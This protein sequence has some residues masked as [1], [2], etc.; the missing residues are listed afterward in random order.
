MTELERYNQY[1][2]AWLGRHLMKMHPGLMD[3][4]HYPELLSFTAA[5]IRHVRALERGQAARVRRQRSDARRNT[6]TGRMRQRTL[7]DPQLFWY[8]L[9]LVSEDR[10]DKAAGD[11]DLRLE[12]I[13]RWLMLRALRSADW[14][15]AAFSCQFFVSKKDHAGLTGWPRY[16]ADL[17]SMHESLAAKGPFPEGVAWSDGGKACFDGIFPKQ[18]SAAPKLAKRLKLKDW[19]RA[20]AK[21]PRIVGA[22]QRLQPPLGAPCFEKNEKKIVKLV[23]DDEQALKDFVHGARSDFDGAA[24]AEWVRRKELLH[25]FTCP[26][27]GLL[28]HELE[29]F[30]DM[31]PTFDTS[32]PGA[33]IEPRSAPPEPAVEPALPP[34]DLPRLQALLEKANE[35]AP[36]T[37]QLELVV[38]ATVIG[39]VRLGERRLF[40]VPIDTLLLV[41]ALEQPDAPL[42]AVSLSDLVDGGEAALETEL[43]ILKLTLEPG[44]TSDDE[45]IVAS[46]YTVPSGEA[47]AP[48]SWLTRLREAIADLRS[49]RGPG[50]VLAMVAG[51]IAAFL[52]WKERTATESVHHAQANAAS[53][54]AQARA[55]Q[56]RA[57]AYA[58]VLE[59][60]R[61]ADGL[62]ERPLADFDLA[63]AKPDR[64]DSPLPGT[65]G[66]RKP[67]GFDR[68]LQDDPRLQSSF[69]DALQR[70]GEALAPMGEAL[71]KAGKRDQ[72]IQLFEYLHARKGA[73][74]DIGFALG[75]LYKDVDNQK[76]I[77]VYR[78]MLDPNEKDPRVLHYLGWSLYESGDSQAAIDSLQR[79]LVAYDR[80]AQD[81][82]RHGADPLPTYGKALLNLGV[83]YANLHQDA[84]ATEYF[85]KAR[86]SFSEAARRFGLQDPKVAFSFAILEA[87]QDHWE[88]ALQALQRALIEPTYLQRAKEEKAF[89]PLRQVGHPLH[90]SFED[91]LARA[92]TPK[93]TYGMRLP[94]DFDPTV[95]TE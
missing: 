50:F 80:A 67:A 44:E 25:V 81:S 65:K 29:N 33:A 31:V 57:D 60:R 35:T 15:Q 90:E 70:F 78:S 92:G 66:A 17:G 4:G 28:R 56:E 69:E 8:G 53:A 74:K 77:A 6:F 37:R 93:Q 39:S 52:F 27:C 24:K 88:E 87:R 22:R 64:T 83:I 45:W 23:H 40:M 95:F 41:R 18:T 91:L 63:Y 79:A 49:D 26:T 47:V 58:T 85:A 21:K 10:L 34:L 5:V 46:E 76:A 72:A 11:A 55:G 73:P 3:P 36:T 38:D 43:G 61:E 59:V 75:E 54:E 86:E 71:V 2:E 42:L 82:R 16:E 7:D 14:R 62:P 12:R 51:I 94:S 48:S 1:Y 20:G 19:E 30:E 68:A 89:V 84:K 32:P 13:I 9:Y